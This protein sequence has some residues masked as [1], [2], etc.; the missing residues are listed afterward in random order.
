MKLPNM[1][2]VQVAKDEESG[3]LY[4]V[5]TSIEGLALSVCGANFTE[6]V[7]NIGDALELYCEPNCNSVELME[8][9]NVRMAPPAVRAVAYG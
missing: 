1:F 3:E 8:R 4:T 5:G 6:L 9:L 2:E 7:N